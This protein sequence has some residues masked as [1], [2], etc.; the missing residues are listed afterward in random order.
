MPQPVSTIDIATIGRSSVAGARGSWARRVVTV[1][2]PFSS[3]ACWALTS[4]F[5][6]T[7]LIW[8][9]SIQIGGSVRS[10]SDA[11]LDIA[12][13]RGPLDDSHRIID[14]LVEVGEFLL[15]LLL[16]GEI[17]QPLDDGGA[18]LGFADDQVHVLGVRYSCPAFSAATDARR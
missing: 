5:M 12:Q 13:M 6:T 11:D 9:A 15:R 1:M 17:Q 7:C 4:M 3:T 18:A 8:S 14:D 2:L 16:A 10:R